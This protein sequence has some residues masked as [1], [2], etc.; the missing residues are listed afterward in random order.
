MVILRAGENIRKVLIK[1]F[2]DVDGKLEEN[3]VQYMSGEVSLNKITDYIQQRVKYD[4]WYSYI[5][6]YLTFDSFHYDSNIGM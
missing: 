1:L 2:V 6:R 5:F 3:E 4:I